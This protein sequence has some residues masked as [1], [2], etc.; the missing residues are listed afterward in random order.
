MEKNNKLKIVFMG[1]PD[2][3]VPT[4]SKLYENKNFD[5]KYVFTKKDSKSNRGQQISYS[6]VKEKALECGLDIL[7][8]DSLKDNQDII[9]KLE[10]VAPDF[11]VVVAY[12]KIL[13]KEILAIPKYACINGHASLL[14]KYRG[15]APIQSAIL[16]GENETGVT[17]MLM[18][19][20]LDTGDI[21]KQV[22]VKI[23]KK[24]TADSLFSK[25]S[26]VTASAIYDTILQ[27]DTITPIKQD[28]S[29]ATK[30]LIIKKEYGKIDF[31][32][33][34]ATEID[35][36]VR[37]YTSWPSAYFEANG[38]QY[39][40][41]DVDVVDNNFDFENIKFIFKNLFVIKKDLFA[42]C[43]DSV[44]KINLIQK[45]G[46]NKLSSYEFINGLKI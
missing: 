15:A 24:E 2:F 20:D 45:S 30:S 32:I 33:E 23:E 42:K 26:T 12:G 19:E 18:N 36:K 7:Q 38:V 46:K 6:K 5:I 9:D 11:I 4:L 35:R 44:L 34:T 27:F 8:P 43:K 21:L 40:L 37:A 41:W 17:T 14:P 39:K 31:D 13:T 25:L 10:K 3:A 29:M 1:T 16:N 22:K 28:D